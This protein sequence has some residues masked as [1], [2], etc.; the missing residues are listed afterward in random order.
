MS[1][2]RCSRSSQPQSSCPRARRPR[3]RRNSRSVS[4]AASTGRSR[5][6]STTPARTPRS[7]QARHLPGGRHRHGHRHDGLTIQGTKKNA[8]KV[9]L[10]ARTP[11][12]RKVSPPTTG[13]RASNVDDVR[14]LQHDRAQVPRQRLLRR[15]LQRLPDEEPAAR[16][17][18]A[19]TACSP[20]TARRA[21]DQVGRL[22]PR[23]LGL[24]RRRDAAR[25]TKPKW[26][27]LD[28]LDGYENVLGYSGTNSKYVKITNSNFYNN[29]AGVVP[30][31]LDSRALSSRTPT[32][33]SRTTTSSGT[34]S[35][36]SCPNSKVQ[37]VSNGGL[38]EVGG[39]HD[40]LPDRRRRGSARRRRLDRSRQPDL[41]QLQVGRRGGLRPV[42]N[43]GDNAISTNNQFINNLMGRGGTDTNAGRLLHRRR[44]A[45]ATASGQRQLDLRPERDSATTRQP[46]SELP[47]ARPAPAAAAA[48]PATASSSTSWP[49]T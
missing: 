13:S 49:A 9:V 30:N 25:R 31:T 40:Q 28:H 3:R 47:G 45:A 46:L 24:L 11:R 17:S 7:S 43:E 20:S 23:R 21:D 33:S 14:I 27:R 37:T 44:R 39:E 35:T 12:I 34:T 48:A 29:G 16:R 5:T 41:R 26:T 10:R 6:R 42:G 1:A 15:R 22:R 38:G 4:T 36:T 8:K 18:T 19:P 2:E 32:G